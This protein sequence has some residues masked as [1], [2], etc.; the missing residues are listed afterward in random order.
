MTLRMDEETATRVRTRFRDVADDV[1]AAR[2]DLTGLVGELG[3]G[4]GEFAAQISAA[5]HDFYGSWQAT[6]EVL[7]DSASLVASNTNAL[8]LDLVDLDRGAAADLDLSPGPR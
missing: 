1:E 8:H 4:A 2:S 3:A 5:A 7:A 6:Y